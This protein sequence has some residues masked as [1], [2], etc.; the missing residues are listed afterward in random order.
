[1]GLLILPCNLQ[2][3]LPGPPRD[4]VVTVVSLEAVQVQAAWS[5]AQPCRGV[6]YTLLVRNTGSNVTAA[7]AL[8]PSD[9]R[10][11]GDTVAMLQP[12]GLMLSPGGQ[13]EL[14][15]LATT[16]NASSNLVRSCLIHKTHISPMNKAMTS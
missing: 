2:P 13:Y 7:V 10:V 4:V 3:Q 6:G 14:R 15:V 9:V 1:M 11:V 5:A 12:A 8:R 16:S